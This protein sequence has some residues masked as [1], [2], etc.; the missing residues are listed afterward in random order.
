MNCQAAPV[1]ENGIFLVTQK[2]GIFL[3]K[4]AGDSSA[5]LSHVKYSFAE[6]ERESLILSS[7]L[8]LE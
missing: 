8:I 6:K 1:E 3:V 7:E 5:E 2:N 4:Q